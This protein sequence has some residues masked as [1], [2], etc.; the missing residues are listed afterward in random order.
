[1]QKILI[2]EDDQ[3]V[4]NIYRNKL[5]VAGF[6][7]EVSPTG[8][9]GCLQAVNEKPNVIILDL[10]LP[11]MTGIEVIKKNPLGRIDRQDS[12]HR[13]FQHLFDTAH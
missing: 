10:S 1:M 3:L 12:H 6:Q 9:D 7:V 13:F 4:A 8:E 2:I 11:K 5:A